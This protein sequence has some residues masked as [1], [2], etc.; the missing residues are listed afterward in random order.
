[1]KGYYDKIAPTQ[2]QKMVKGY[3]KDVKL[4]QMAV[5]VEGKNKSA[6]E[7]ASALGMTID[8]INA[9]PSDEKWAAINSVKGKMPMLHLPVTDK[10]REHI[11]KGQKAYKRGGRVGYADGG[12]V[13]DNADGTGRQHYDAYG[14]VSDA[15]GGPVRAVAYDQ[16]R[17]NTL[18]QQLNEGTYG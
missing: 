7:I 3:D 1:M 11:L 9:M 4:G 15:Q 16:D 8:Q 10:M 2:L 17:V 12:L 6:D 14:N 18:A 13:T 5:P